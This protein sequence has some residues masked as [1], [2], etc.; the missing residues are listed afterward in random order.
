MRRLYSCN[1]STTENTDWIKGKAEPK[2]GG[3]AF[4]NEG[5]GESELIVLKVWSND[6]DDYLDS[7]YLDLCFVKMACYLA[8]GFNRT[9]LRSI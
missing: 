6:S 8:Y 9:T 1:K 5:Q 7:R 4:K 2:Y 3:K